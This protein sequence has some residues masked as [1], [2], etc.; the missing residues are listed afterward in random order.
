M[1]KLEHN[2][3][4][5]DAFK[6]RYV[7][8]AYHLRS[9]K[10]I[11]EVG[12][13]RTPISSFLFSRHESV[14][15]VDPYVKPL[16]ADELNGAPCRVR[17]VPMLLEDYEMRGD[18]DCFVFMGLDYYDEKNMPLC[19]RLRDLVRSFDHVVLDYAGRYPTGAECFKALDLPSSFHRELQVVLEVEG[20]EWGNLS[21]SWMPTGLTTRVLSVLRHHRVTARKTQTFSSPSQYSGARA[22]VQAAEAGEG[23]RKEEETDVTS[24]LQRAGDEV[25]RGG[26][27][28]VRGWKLVGLVD[29]MGGGGGGGDLSASKMEAVL[30]RVKD[31]YQAA[32]HHARERNWTT[33]R[34]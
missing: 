3:Y 22:V 6:S 13:Y 15:T 33:S 14:T 12:G 18:E 16:A 10:N 20:N 5:H 32:L 4:E 7:L 21:G 25:A 11:L 9:C 19:S 8:A 34:V 26:D 28:G 29:D 30:P 24:V 1:H 27:N 23:A 31:N 2:F 17:H